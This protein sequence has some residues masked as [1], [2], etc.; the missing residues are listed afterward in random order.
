MSVETDIINYSCVALLLLICIGIGIYHGFR[1][2]NN[3]TPEEY[4]LGNRS[5]GLVPVAISIFVTFQ[6]AISLM[7]IPAE[8]YLYGT[9]Q[10]YMQVGMTLSL[11]AALIIAA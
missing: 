2:K 4:L 8:M 9:M 6:S 11:V 7:G 5:M 1:G 3:Q 10:V